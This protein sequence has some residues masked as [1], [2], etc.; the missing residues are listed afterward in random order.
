MCGR[1][2]ASADPD[3]LVLKHRLDEVT[4][5]GAAACAPRYNIAP[6]DTVPAIVERATQTGPVR[7]LVAL[8]WGLVPSWSRD[9]SCAARMIN[10]RVETVTQKPSF[11]RA[12]SQRR[13]LLPALGYY[14]WRKET[15]DG[16]PVKQPYFMQ[17]AQGTLMHMAGLYEFW[18]SPDGWLMSTTIITTS[19]TDDLGWIHDR[20]PMTVADTDAWLDPCLTDGDAAR[21]LLDPLAFLRPTKVSRAVNNVA[22]DGASLL[23]PI[24]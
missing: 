14:E 9:M 20:M 12:M 19:A 16:K 5:E 15:D 6:T 7:K 21:D 13:C 2:A 4:D 18:R 23:Q 17:P 24:D 22:S 8:R 11:R 1:Y 10:A 3:E